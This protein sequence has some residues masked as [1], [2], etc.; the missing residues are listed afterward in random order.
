MQH[1]KD[2]SAFETITP[3]QDAWARKILLTRT[4]QE[5][6]ELN[7]DSI[8]CQ[9]LVSSTK[10]LADKLA[11]I[12]FLKLDKIDKI[13]ILDIG[14]GCGQL[15]KLATMLGHHAVG[16]ELGWAISDLE[17]IYTHYNTTI[18]ELEVKK[19]QEFKLPEKYDLITSLRIV[20]DEGWNSSDWKFFKENCFDYLTDT[21]SLFLKTNL[22]HIECFEQEQVELAF[23]PSLIGWNNL[24]FHLKK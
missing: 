16:T 15:V 13:K 10:K 23:G 19:Q 8:Y 18:F 6:T 12:N 9:Y 5:W 24:T 2:R 22:K 4:V 17:S 21:G 14:A 3:E 7:S 1:F 20:F 11:T